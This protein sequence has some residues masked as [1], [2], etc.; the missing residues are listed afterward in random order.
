MKFIGFLFIC[1]AFA[2]DL[3]Q[4]ET[5]LYSENGED[6]VIAKIFDTIGVD[7]HY[8]V[9]L[10]ASDG[11]TD[12]NTYLLRLQGW[13]C[14]LLDRA[15]ENSNYHLYKQFITKENINELLAQY[16][17]PT[18]FDLLSIDIDYNT[19]HI[20][21]AL[22]EKYQPNVVVIAYN[23]ELGPYDNK[24][25]AYRP[26]FSGDQT[27]YYGA[28][29]SALTQLAAQKDYSLAYIGK[30]NLIFTRTDLNFETHFPTEFNTRTPDPKNRAYVTY[31]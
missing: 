20:W 7:H 22:D 12:S 25:V 13:D 4:F 27:N 28:S 1:A 11:I 5:S 31:E 9:D 30:S 21:Q 19:F 18:H 23:P 29:L 26:F 8:C 17:V 16:N 14:L 2:T 6:G 3:Q 24:V 10:G 15:Y